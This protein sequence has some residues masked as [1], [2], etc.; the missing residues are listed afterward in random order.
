MKHLTKIMATLAVLT[1]V[2]G[3]A[4]CA[5][6]S[7]YSQVTLTEA[8]GI[9]AEAERGTK[10]QMATTKGA[11]VVKEGDIVVISPD[12]TKGS[13]HL[14]ITSSDKGT[15]VYDDDV[16]GRV[17]FTQ[18]FEPGTYDVTTYG[19]NVTGSLVVAVHSQEEWD[20]EN[21]SLAEAL[22]EAGIDLEIETESED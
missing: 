1:L 3:F 4:A 17:L 12:V 10:D 7:T 14:T 19:N 11:L 8:V 15:V 9:K 22:D 2:F 5:K 13:F 20:F 16:D 21:D 18:A 6:P